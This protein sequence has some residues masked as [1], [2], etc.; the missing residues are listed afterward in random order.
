[1]SQMLKN[2]MSLLEGQSSPFSSCCKFGTDLESS[3]AAMKMCFQKWCF[4][5]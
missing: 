4:I 2:Q 3:D 1:M 5:G